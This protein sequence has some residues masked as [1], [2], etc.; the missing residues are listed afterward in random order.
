MKKNFYS[1]HTKKSAI[2]NLNRRPLFRE[3]EIWFCY[4]GQ[5]VGHEQDGVGENFLRPVVVLKKFNDSLLWAVP[6]TSASRYGSFYFQFYFRGVVNSAILSQVRL[7]DSKRLKYR[8]GYIS[9]DHF[10]L[11]KTKIRQLLV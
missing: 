10:N 8:A 2:N 7:L 11:L 1:W 9:S 5:N 6:L 3:R 4:L